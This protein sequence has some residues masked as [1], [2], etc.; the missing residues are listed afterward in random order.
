MFERSMKRVCLLGVLFVLLGGCSS[1]GMVIADHFDKMHEIAHVHEADCGAMGRALVGY[2]DANHSSISR[3][4]S[5]LGNADMKEA[6]RLYRTS[7]E[8]HQATVH[9]QTA[10]MDAFWKKLSSLVLLPEKKV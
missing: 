3:A 5:D 9:C 8:L 4:S 2:L 1:S 6:D 7:Y 10:E